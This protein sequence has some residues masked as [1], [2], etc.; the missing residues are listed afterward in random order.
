MRVPKSE[1]KMTTQPNA[2]T[3]TVEFSDNQWWVVIVEN[4]EKFEQ[5]YDS[6]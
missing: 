4:G 1:E 3:V 6:Q 2:D 5:T